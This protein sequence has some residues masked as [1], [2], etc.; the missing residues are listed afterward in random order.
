MEHQ[1]GQDW[2]PMCWCQHGRMKLFQVEK[3]T[4]NFGRYF[5]KCPRNVNHP[6]N[7]LWCDVWHKHD[8][9]ENL[10]IFLQFPQQSPTTQASS[11]SHACTPKS[12]SMNP[13]YKPEIEVDSNLC[14]RSHSHS[15]KSDYTRLAGFGVGET[16]HIG[17]SVILCFG[18][19]V[20]VFALFSLALLSF[21][22]G[23]LSR[24]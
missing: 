22:V 10:P 12:E 1:R 23:R 4:V 13:T 2:P 15:Q 11:S 3:P 8:S 16:R 19:V 7:F 20:M 9:P 5:Y 17:S 21:L 14:C 24:S 6:K 18:I